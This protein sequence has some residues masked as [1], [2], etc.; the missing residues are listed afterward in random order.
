MK[1]R[2]LR[3]F[4]QHPHRVLLLLADVPELLSHTVC[5]VLSITVAAQ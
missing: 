2:D 5:L 4:L 1:Y 3:D